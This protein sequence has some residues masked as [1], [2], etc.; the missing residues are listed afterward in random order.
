MNS[1][2]DF[3]RTDCEEQSVTDFILTDTVLRDGD[4]VDIEIRDGRIDRVVPSGEGDEGAFDTDQHF[5]ADGRLVTPPFAEPHTHLATANTFAALLRDDYEMP[6]PDRFG[7]GWQMY[8]D[9]ARAGML[10]SSSI[11]ERASTQLEWL[12]ANGVTAVRTHV[13]TSARHGNE[14]VEALLELESTYE[15][16]IDLQIVGL[17]LDTLTGSD[18]NLDSLHDALDAGVDVVGGIPHKEA[19]REDGVEH[20]KTIVDLANSYDRPLDPHIDESDDPQS[21]FTGVMAAQVER[22]SLDSQVTASHL[23]AMHSYPNAYAD[24]L[25]GL[26]ARNDI[27]V[28]TNPTTNAEL[29]GRRDDYPRRRGHTRVDELLE[30]GV[31]V[32]IGQDNM[33]DKYHPYGD[34]DPLGEVLFLA[35]FGHLTS[36]HDISTLWEMVLENNASV[37]GLDSYG[38]EPGNEG[39]F[40]VFDAPDSYNALRTRAP[41]RLVVR[42]GTPVARRESGRTSVRTGDEWEDVD[43]SV[44]V[45]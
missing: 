32:G 2:S 14:L 11:V 17:P 26:L 25:R 13:D 1:D 10:E 27:S 24:K 43:F 35:H 9:L 39:S 28:I 8:D 15:D 23:T 18:A 38:L 7:V 22:Q 21:R 41:R 12:L 16:V 31:T 29:Q 37:L 3:I 4:V 44:P 20:V 6:R 34:C 40:V 33:V 5:D 36:W 30:A 19:T 45:S 42:E